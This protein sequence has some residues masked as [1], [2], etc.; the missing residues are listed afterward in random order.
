MSRIEEV[1]ERLKGRREAALIGYVMGGLPSPEKTPE[2]AEALVN[3]GVDILELGIPFSD[4]I[5]DGPTIQAAANEALTI[6]V[7]PQTV[8]NIVK[9]IRGRSDV[10]IVLLT[11]YNPVYK[12][13]VNRFLEASHRHGV[14]GIIVPD[15]PVEEAD[16]YRRY[17]KTYGVDPIFLASPSTSTARLQRII[18]ATS[19]FLYLVSLYGVTGVRQQVGEDTLDL[20]RRFRSHVA[21]RTNLAVGFGISKPEHV[22]NIVAAGA[23]GA[24]VGSA[25][26][27][28]I[29]EEKTSE[30]KMLG[31][32]RELAASLKDA[33]RS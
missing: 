12:M 33:T 11:Y 26:V 29:G 21:G 1:F 8:F 2:V 3:G 16:D 10:P 19:G 27:R 24:I 30:G 14:D 28:I 9:Q 17:A 20:V 23:D 32:L 5:A 22:R 13:G 15:L 18:D 7:T 25:F 4:P 6:G 31:R